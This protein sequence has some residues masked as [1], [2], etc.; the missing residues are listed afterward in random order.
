MVDGNLDTQSEANK[1]RLTGENIS[2]GPRNQ[3]LLIRENWVSLR[4]QILQG[5]LVSPQYLIM[6][7][8]S[9]RGKSVFMKY[10]IFYILFEARRR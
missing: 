2:L 9:G 3:T 6:K 10:L 1:W 5:T 4:D 8:K 7:G